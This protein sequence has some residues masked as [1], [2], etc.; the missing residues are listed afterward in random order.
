MKKSLNKKKNQG[1]KR[2]QNSFFA[3]LENDDEE[4]N[5][6]DD[7]NSSDSDEE[8]RKSKKKKK[9]RVQWFI[10]LLNKILW[11]KQKTFN[12]KFVHDFLFRIVSSQQLFDIK[13]YMT[14]DSTEN[15][16]K[17]NIFDD[18]RPKTS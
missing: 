2:Q 16:P 3:D 13:T 11:R 12:S 15:K 8:Y 10:V 9:T 7:E 6:T 1:A 14:I 4:N 17:E 5:E 18:N